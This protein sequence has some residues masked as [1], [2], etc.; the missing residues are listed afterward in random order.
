MERF[1]PDLEEVNYFVVALLVTA[2]AYTAYSGSFTVESSLFFTAVAGL[3]ILTREL[4][5]RIVAQWM[6][7]DTEIHLSLKGS[8]ITLIGALIAFLTQLPVIILFPVHNTYSIT[9]YEHW[10]RQVDGMWSKREYHLVSGGILALLIGWLIT[11]LLGY[12]TVALAFALFALF[13]MLPFDY[14]KIP[15]DRLDG[16][17]I[18]RVN[19]FS[20]LIF[21]TAILIALALAV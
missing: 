11:Y 3:V 19:G 10:G 16:S 17:I 5:Q 21:F 12:S 1:K 13:Q 9:S 4:G 18:L 14:S 8:I 15:T 7:A 2:A 20:W 6:K